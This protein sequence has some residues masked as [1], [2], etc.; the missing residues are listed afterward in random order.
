[1]VALLEFKYSEVDNKSPKFKF[2]D[3]KIMSAIKI[4]QKYFGLNHAFVINKNKKIFF[5]DLDKEIYGEEIKDIPDVSELKE[6]NLEI[7]KKIEKEFLLEME[8]ERLNK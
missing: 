4:Y 7:D 2:I 6:S 3:Q 5:W 8:Q 1:M